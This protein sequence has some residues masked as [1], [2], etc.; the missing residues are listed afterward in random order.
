MTSA[1]VL[2]VF[3]RGVTRAGDT[4]E[5][6]PASLARVTAAVD[7]VMTSDPA[8]PHRPRVV[9]TGGWPEASAGAE[10]PPLG[11]REGDLMLRAARDA[12]LADHADLHAETRSRSTLE[13]LLHTVEDQLLGGYAFEPTHP[14]GLVSHPWHL[15]RV[16]F[17][18]G[19][20]LRLSGAALLDVPATGGEDDGDRGL[21]LASRIGFLGARHGTAL[22]R[23][24][25][26][27]VALARRAEQLR[28]RKTVS[29]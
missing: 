22:L 16:R 7:Y 11:N 8:G 23:R 28:W 26:R 6:T 1:S 10:P 24:E 18:A 3:G 12:G 14:L 29:G 15:P 9:F 5:L 21:L 25:R 19:K 17:L 13:N 27:M 2:L 20:V 4:W